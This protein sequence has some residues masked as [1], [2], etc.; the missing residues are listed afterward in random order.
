MEEIFNDIE[1]LYADMNSFKDLVSFAAGCNHDGD[2][3]LIFI[4]NQLYI[5]SSKL[6]KILND[7][8]SII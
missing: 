6:N 5:Y 2:E 3:K 8:H 4:S 7:M 1:T